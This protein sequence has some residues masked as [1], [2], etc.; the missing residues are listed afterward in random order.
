MRKPLI[1][2]HQDSS[3]RASRA[4]PKE[5]RM[6]PANIALLVAAVAQLI[7]ALASAFAVI[8]GSP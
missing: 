5:D 8:R 4:G 2:L 6:K 7:T 1:P 3:S